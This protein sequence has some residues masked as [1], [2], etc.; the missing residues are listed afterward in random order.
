VVV[1]VATA[2]SDSDST[3]REFVAEAVEGCAAASVIAVNAAGIGSFRTYRRRRFAFYCR[4]WSGPARSRMRRVRLQDL[5]AAGPPSP[6]PAFLGGR[7][8]APGEP[9]EKEEPGNVD[10]RSGYGLAA[11]GGA[12]SCG[13]FHDGREIGRRRRRR[14]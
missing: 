6:P 2:T 10:I 12:E 7:N 4:L 3:H 8:R 14:G 11:R 1:E 9:A 5:A 13:A